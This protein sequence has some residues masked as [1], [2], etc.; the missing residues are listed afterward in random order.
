[1]RNIKKLFIYFGK[2]IYLVEKKT[3]KKGREWKFLKAEISNH[4][5]RKKKKYSKNS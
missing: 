2:N 3:K 5:E 1:M 4:V